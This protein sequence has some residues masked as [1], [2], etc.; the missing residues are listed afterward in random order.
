MLELRTQT[1]RASPGYELVVADRLTPV[2]RAQLAALD[3][4]PDLYGLLRPRDG[5]ELDPRAVTHDTALLFL[6]LQ[7][8]GPLPSYVERVGGG[9]AEAAIA[10]LV[11]DGVLEVEHEGA[12]LSGV[13]A[14]ELLLAPAAAVPRGRTVA[15]THAA[16]RYGQALH[17]LPPDTLALRLYLYGRRP[18]TAALRAALPTEDAVE[19]ALG[20]APGGR[21]R[22]V[23]G[24]AWAEDPRGEGAVAWRMLRPRQA[25]AGSGRLGGAKLYVSA[26]VDRVAETIAAVAEELAGRPGVA[27]FKVARDVGGLCRPDKLVCYFARL[28]DL[29]EAAGALR[30]RLDG[31]A[32]H[33]VPFTAPIDPEGLL[34]WGLDPPDDPA[35]PAGRAGE[36]WRLRVTRTV[37]ELLV[38]A[39]G[40]RSRT[41]EPWELA[42]DRLRLAGVDPDTWVP[43]ARVWAV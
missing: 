34:S 32:A 7:A 36:S 3:P 35:R 13:A 19:E 16:L 5:I 9:S 6:T 10:T 39:R 31:I 4:D 37:A 1:F 8:P 12:F 27:G 15:L 30:P 23:L 25:G 42:L 29:H 2:E 43:S 28:E 14:H 41:R 18:V 22:S 40:S 17:T 38:A 33:G 21:V 24:R 20:L 26:A 11:L